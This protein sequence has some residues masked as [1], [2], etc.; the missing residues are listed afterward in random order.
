MDNF[1]MLDQNKHVKYLNR[2]DRLRCILKGLRTLI[3]TLSDEEIKTA[4][5]SLKDGKSPGF[6]EINYDIVKQNFNSLLVPLKCI[7]H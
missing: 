5:F 4:F 7:F 2:K 3:L 6:D 1:S